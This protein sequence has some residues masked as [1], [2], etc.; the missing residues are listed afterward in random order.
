MLKRFFTIFTACAVSISMLLPTTAV[1]AND[2]PASDSDYDALLEIST[3]IEDETDLD[4]FE[5]SELTM[6]SEPSSL[7]E[8]TEDDFLT[9]RLEGEMLLQVEGNGE[10][11]YVDPVY[12]GKE[13][14]ADGKSAHSLLRRRAMGIINANLEK[15]PVGEERADLNTCTAPANVLGRRLRGRILL[16]VEEHGEAWYVWP[17]NCRRYYVGTYD[18]AYQMM[19][20]LSLG[21]TN[22]NLAKIRNAKRQQIK[23]NLRH[24]V[25]YIAWKYDITIEQAIKWIKEELKPV[26]V[27]FPE[28]VEIQDHEDLLRARVEEAHVLVE[29]LRESELPPL[30]PLD[31]DEA[32]ERL[33]SFKENEFDEHV[34]TG[35]VNCV[36]SGGEWGEMSCACPDDILLTNSYCVNEEGL[37]GGELGDR[38]A[39]D[40]NERLESSESD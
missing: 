27:C 7:P 29:C 18:R 14:L 37:P 1:F 40:L 30:R 13:Y 8:E 11:Y 3:L 26:R 20:K 10:V 34:G 36:R 25:H 39:N 9:D 2:A 19:K 4:D 31:R 22:R 23:R 21:I 33:R 16:Q 35:E 17:K 38:I 32:I 24:Y 5:A 28:K 15:I 12:G 6:E